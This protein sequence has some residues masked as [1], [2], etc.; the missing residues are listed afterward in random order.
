M[1]EVGKARLSEA[2]RDRFDRILS[3]RPGVF[4]STAP[5]LCAA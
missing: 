2:D 1:I 3:V 4:D 5:D